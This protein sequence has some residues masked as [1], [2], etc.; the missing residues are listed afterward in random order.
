MCADRSGVARGHASSS[1][2]MKQ[3]RRRKCRCCYVLY[4]P[5]PY[6]VSHQRYC[7]RPACQA[8]S[9]KASQRR[10]LAKPANRDYHGKRDH[11]ARVRAWRQAHPHYWRRPGL[12]LQD[13]LP[14]ELVDPESIA[15]E[16]NE[17]PASSSED[18]AVNGLRLFAG[19]NAIHAPSET[20]VARAVPNAPL[21]DLFLSQ[22]PLFVGLVSSLTDALQEDIVTF[23]ARLQTRGQ[24]ILRKGPGIAPKGVASNDDAQTCVVR[25]ADPAGAPAV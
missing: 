8:A 20:W 21:Q 3:I 17:E 16:L 18:T 9:R 22:D 25:G 11:C 24:A 5:D 15:L 23:M 6:N 14:T 1:S 13:V 4:V 2:G 10:W 19:E 7:T 12:A